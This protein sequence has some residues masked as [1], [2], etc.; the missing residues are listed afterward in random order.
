MPQLFIAV[1][2]VVTERRGR[3]EWVQAG[4]I[5][6]AGSWPLE[7][8]SHIFRPLQVRFRAPK[9]NS[10]PAPPP[11]ENEEGATSPATSPAAMKRRGGRPRKQHETE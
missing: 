4:D 6:E 1:E 3:S 5:A 8:V 10:A 11:N 9:D 7:H 2:T